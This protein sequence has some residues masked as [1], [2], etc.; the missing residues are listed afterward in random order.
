MHSILYTVC[1]VHIKECTGP[2]I[3]PARSLWPFY[4]IWI[5]TGAHCHARLNLIISCTKTALNVNNTFWMLHS[6]PQSVLS[7][8]ISFRCRQ[9]LN[10]CLKMYLTEWMFEY[11][12]CNSISCTL[13]SA[14]SFSWP[15]FLFLWWFQSQFIF[16]CQI[17]WL[18]CQVYG[19]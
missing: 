3:S 6:L 10:L 5:W 2:V 17:N 14:F 15:W 11:I 4:V 7:R 8:V 12:S 19:W 13:W 9:H 1:A 16:A 18:Y